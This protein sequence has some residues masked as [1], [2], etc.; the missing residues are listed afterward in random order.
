MKLLRVLAQ[1]GVVLLDKVPAD[2]VLGEVAVTCRGT[3]V[4]R[5][6]GLGV[7]VGSLVLVLVTEVAVRRHGNL[8]VWWGRRVEK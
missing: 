5:G 6:G 8:G 2:L 4:G 3:G 7:L 1:G